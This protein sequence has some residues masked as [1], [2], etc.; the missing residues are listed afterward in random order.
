ME[1]TNHFWVCTDPAYTSPPEHEEY[2]E[3]DRG[4]DQADENWKERQIDVTEFIGA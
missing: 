2:S 3:W 1:L 4:L